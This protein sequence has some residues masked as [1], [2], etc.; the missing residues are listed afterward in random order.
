MPTILELQRS[1]TRSIAIDAPPEEV[2]RFIADATNLPRWAPAFAAA[3]RPNRNHWVVSTPGG[4]AE[5]VVASNPESGT[6]DILSAAD[7]T[8]GAFARV[9]SNGPGSEVLFTLFFE[10]GTP[11]QAVVAQMTVVDDELANIKQMTQQSASAEVLSRRP[12]ALE[13]DEP[14]SR[15]ATL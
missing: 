11:E 6:L 13:V 7:R 10:P 15:V 2:H 8:R 5:I 12:A 3:I 1:E 9:I 14:R 4:E